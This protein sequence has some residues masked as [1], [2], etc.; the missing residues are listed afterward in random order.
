M[1]IFT[2]FATGFLE[3]SVQ[4][5]KEKAAAELEQKKI[6]AE[7]RDTLGTIVFDLIKD[8]KLTGDQG[9]ELLGRSDLTRAD[10]AGMVNTMADVAGTENFGGYKLNL[11]QEYDYQKMSGFERANVFWESFENQ[12]SSE[13]GFQNALSYF[14]NNEQA[15]NQLANAVRKNEYELR[16]GNVTRQTA[17]NKTGV[18][19]YINLPERYGNSSRLFDELGFQSVSQE[20]DTAI[21]ESVID[22]DPE[23]EVAVLMNTRQTGGPIEPVA[24]G[25]D[26]STYAL[27][28]EMASNTGYRTVQDMVS[29]FSV[30]ADFRQTDET[31]EQF[32]FRQND[33]LTKAATLHGEGFADFLSN[34]ALASQA[35]TDKYL[36]RLKDITGGDREQ[37]I[38]IM[39]MMVKT[40]ANTF[41]KVRQN[42]YAG[43]TSQRIKPVVTGSQFVE[44]V[45]GMKVDDF[46]E[47]FKAQEDAVEYLDRLQ[48]LESELGEQ[49]GTGWIRGFAGTAKRFGIQLKQGGTTLAN[50]FRTNSDFTQTAD[51]VNMS[52]L[53]A[54]IAEVRPDINLGDISEVDAL[55]LTLAAKMARA[56]DPSGRL[57]NQDFE[58]QL[59]RLGDGPFE[60]PQDI[61]RKL[62]TVRRDF[63]KD[64]QYKRRLKS[65]IDDQTALTPQVARTVQ[66][67][68]RL[69][70]LERQ[71]GSRRGTE[72][73]VG[74]DQ[75]TQ[76]ITGQETDPPSPQ[77][78]SPYPNK[79]GTTF[80]TKDGK[81]YKDPQGTQLVT[82]SE[83]A[84]ANPRGT[85]S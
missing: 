78:L 61:A 25:V 28:S 71:R 79:D 6:D 69:K 81:F 39:S 48:A 12:L 60:T 26:K 22:F 51:G 19:D 7:R 14:N 54:S 57:S 47:G 24:V 43:N 49:V 83:F 34:P 21:A 46:N 50:L 18:I 1:G 30:G 42:R 9:A 35:D 58:V 77:P 56:I 37:Q 73:V 10:I 66:A 36:K 29:D 3:G 31:P 53:Q 20:A 59:R 23:T 5:Q 8:G 32:A 44:R 33:L 82:P 62:Q 85:A 40:P 65:V 55:R 63:E 52:D 27:W 68:L 45:S 75:A 64:I 2:S 4:V 11:I 72:A 13:Q 15:R 80:Y 76:Q 74:S 67:S 70:N 41:Q 84:A 17:A 38:Q 16:L